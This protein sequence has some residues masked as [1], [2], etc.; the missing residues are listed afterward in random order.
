[1]RLP[2]REPVLFKPLVQDASDC[3]QDLDVYVCEK[4]S[5][6]VTAVLVGAYVSHANYWY[7]ATLQPAHMQALLCVCGSR[8]RLDVIDDPCGHCFYAV[9]RVREGLVGCC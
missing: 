5:W 1:M 6:C 8:I 2:R 4:Y 9:W 7:F 3:T